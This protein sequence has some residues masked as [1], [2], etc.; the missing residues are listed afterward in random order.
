MEVD[1][2][3]FWGENL[4]VILPEVVSSSIWR[5]GYFEES[6]CLY[7]LSVLREGMT[8]VDVGAHFGFF[9]LFGAHLVGKD[10]K[11]LSFE[12]VPYT[13][14]QLVKN[15]A[16]HPNIDTLNCAAF[17]EE[18]DITFHD[19]GLERSAFNSSFGIRA[20][21]MDI[22]SKELVVKARK[23]DNVIKERGYERLD[24][25]K[26]DAE[27]SEIHVLK[28]MVDTLKTYRP[29]IIVEV[30]DFGISGVPKSEEIISWLEKRE[31]YPYE[32]HGMELVRHLKKDDYA[33]GNILFLPRR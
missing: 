9:T 26:I 5:N 3:T 20:D 25:V 28:G 21:E 15:A 7:M 33:Y 6:V 17:S 16:G 13:Y 29:S 24:L 31:F 8:F 18:K 4:Q 19:Y 32:A 10:G 22:Q 12:P 2:R 1:A 14:H 11:V 27:S 30:G 23:I